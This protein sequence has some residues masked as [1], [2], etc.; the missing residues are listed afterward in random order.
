MK[1]YE[2]SCGEKR[3]AI[4][5]HPTYSLPTT[6]YKILG[7]ETELKKNNE[8]TI[9]RGQKIYDVLPF[10]KHFGNFAISQ[11]LKDFLDSN[12]ITGWSCFPIEIKGINEQYYAFQVLGKSGEIINLD[13]VNRGLIG[14]IKSQVIASTIDGSD[15]F[16][17]KD[18]LIIL[19]KEHVAQKL[20]QEKF[21]NLVIEDVEDSFEFV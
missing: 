5:I 4:N 21:T 11:R 10:E 16:L 3:G 12:E 17:I 7:A 8:F 18:T 13:A 20:Q 14:Q 9:S 19:I 6:P 15:V 2:L 1:F